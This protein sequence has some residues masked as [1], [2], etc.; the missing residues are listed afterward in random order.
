MEPVVVGIGGALGAVFRYAIGMALAY[1]SFP[2]GTLVV[3]S[4]G[5][6]VLG[7]IMLS[8]INSDLLLF[9]GVGFCGA[10]TTFSSFSYQTVDLWDRG[11]HRMAVWNAGG[12]L[13]VSLVAFFLA[14]L[15][16]G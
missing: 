15:I 16:T 9:M 8:G 10:F 5:S 6:F 7:V 12:N 1:R 2:W 11:D 4:L 13:G 3:N 14:Y